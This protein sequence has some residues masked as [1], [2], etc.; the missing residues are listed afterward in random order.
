MTARAKLDVAKTQR[1]ILESISPVD[2]KKIGEVALLTEEEVEAKVQLA[3]KAFEGWKQKSYKER[4]AYLRRANAYMIRHM[5]EIA[6]TISREMGK[7]P[8]EALSADIFTAMDL[9]DYYG[10]NAPKWLEEQKI[11]LHLLGPLKFKQSKLVFE[12]LG[13]V[14]VIAPWN[15]PFA[16][17]MSGII[18]ALITGNVVLFK[19]ASDVCL[20]GKKIEEVLNRGARLPRG[21]FQLITASSRTVEKTLFKPPVKKVV[22]TG[23][24]EI[25][26]RIMSKCGEHLIPTVLELGG[27]DPM[28]V[29]GDADVELAAKGAVWGAFTNCGQVCASVERC[30][31]HESIYDEFVQRVVEETQRLRVGDPQV[32][33]VGPLVSEEQRRLVKEHIEDAVGSGARIVAGGKIPKRKGFFLEP[34]VLTDVT[35]DMRCIREETFGPT[36]PIMK[37]RTVEEAVR[38]AND[39][40]FG[41]TA[42]VWSRNVKKAEAIARRIEAGTVTVNDHAY[43]YG[44]TDT[45]WQGMKESGVGRSHGLWGLMEFVFPKHINTDH[46]PAGMKRRPWWYP[47]PKNA[48]QLFKLAA[49][50][51]YGKKGR[52]RLAAVARL[53]A[54]IRDPA[55]RKAFMGK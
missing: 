43:T 5:D 12:P 4:A 54:V 9:I 10:K 21:V 40:N 18:G 19:P 50:A 34:T 6:R 39:T 49:R 51:M 26:K 32:S 16:I 46:F 37:F 55:F 44:L 30:Y 20:V 24:T 25:G 13:L 23:S 31:V 35:H 3:Q 17:P 48:Y 15:F 42:S 45:P 11:P 33:E 14:V 38:L 28:V 1:S 8:V 27:K 2:E 36:L 7:P 53:M 41:L 29:L 52:E 22:F 47:Y